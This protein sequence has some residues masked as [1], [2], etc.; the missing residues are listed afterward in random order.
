MRLAAFLLASC[1]ALLAGCA[2]PDLPTREASGA[3]DGLA[4]A[5]ADERRGDDAARD[6]FRHPDATLRFFD[7]QPNHT[8]AEYA[9]GGGWYTK[10]LAP[11]VAEDGHYVAVSFSGE[12]TGIDR[13]VELLSGFEQTFPA[14]VEELS[15]VPAD[16]VS[17]WFTTT[18]PEEVHGTVDRIVIPRMVHNLLRWNIANEELRG[19]RKLLKDD[20]LVGIVQHRAKPDSP[21]AY[22]DGSKG[23]LREADVVALMQV[24]GFELVGRSEINANP[25]DPAD[26]AAGVWTLPPSLRLGE[27]DKDRYLA[28]GESDRA[29]LVFAKAK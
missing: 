16:R 6:A 1:L 24:N 8:V 22:G 17:A 9:P 20:G 27:E 15:G 13:L 7:V 29:T 14:R 10:I 4:E 25:N 26:H 3:F 21:W 28:I 18:A 19:L 23:Y 11:Y 5:I 12:Q 2:T